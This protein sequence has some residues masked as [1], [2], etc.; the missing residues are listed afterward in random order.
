[1]ILLGFMIRAVPVSAQENGVIATE[2]D[3][4]SMGQIPELLEAASITALGNPIVVKQ[5]TIEYNTSVYV[6]ADD[7]L[8]EDLLKK[9]PG[10]EVDENGAVMVNGERVTRVMI[11]G[12]RFFLNDPKLAGRNI[13]AKYVKK[14]KVIEKKSDQAEFSGIDDGERE[15][16]I[17][18]SLSEE[19]GKGVHGNML[20]GMGHDL[21][22]PSASINDDMRLQGSAFISQFRKDRQLSFVANANNTN[23]RASSAPGGQSSSEPAGGGIRTTYM[24]G[25]NAALRLLDDRMDASANYVFN[26]EN[27]DVR[28]HTERQ[29]FLTGRTLDYTSD[30]QQVGKERENRVGARVEHQFSPASSVIFEQQLTFGSDFS[31]DRSV[32]STFSRSDGEDRQTNEGSRSNMSVGQSHSA[33]GSLQYRQRLGIPGRTLVAV[34]MYSVSGSG[35]DGANQSQTRTF[36]ANGGIRDSLIEQSFR[37]ESQR[38]SLSGRLTYTEPVGGGFYL[39]GNY[40]YSMAKTSSF[41]NSYNKEGVFDP[42]YS[43]DINNQTHSH[44]VGFNLKYQHGKTRAQVGLALVPTHTENYT[45]K[46]GV[47]NAINTDVLNWAPQFSFAFDPKPNAS[48]RSTYFGNSSQ[49]APARLMPVPDITNPL[50][51]TMGNP[52]LL[53]I[54]NNAFNLRYRM[55]DKKSF[56]SVNLRIGANITDKPVVNAL[57]YDVNGVQYSM[58]VNGPAHWDVNFNFTYNTPIAKSRFSFYGMMSG[59]YATRSSF[60]GSER[61]ELDSYYASGEFDYQ[62]FHEDYKDIAS[63]SS[64]T[65]NRT[66]TVTAAQ[67]VRLS[68]RDRNLELQCGGRTRVNRSWYTIKQDVAPVWN[69]TVNASANY[70][71]VRV[72]WS[73]DAQASYNWYRGYSSPMD[74]EILLNV[75]V[76]KSL[77]KRRMTLSLQGFDLLAQAKVLRVTDQSNQHREVVSNTLGRYVI[78]TLSWRMGKQQGNRKKNTK[79]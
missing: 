46:R 7:D 34:A 50:H 63:S 64:F 38:K 73:F 21:P 61:M 36:R 22:G 49:P 54:F 57:W 13:L 33:N 20:A 77:F 66:Q 19:M 43:N 16:V 39:E 79:Q 15:T 78:A 41:K 18:L 65:A 53:P 14:L 25:A 69:H 40:T 32:F 27:N 51:I 2:P 4:L 17:D 29:T 10:V 31:D 70:K 76:S 62:R 8:L 23:N 11:D 71:W 9:L 47:S 12:K 59:S 28:H 72:G 3:T 45:T 37:R 58:P 75:R 5:D 67:R 56:S 74:D 6:M 48:F 24:I 68:Y 35:T 1:M 60:V 42:R 52:Y 44:R 26:H 55:S 30:E